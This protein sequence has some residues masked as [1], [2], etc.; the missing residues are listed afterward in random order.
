MT[1][2]SA[3]WIAALALMLALE[4]GDAIDAS[5]W[6]PGAAEAQDP[7]VVPFRLVNGFLVVSYGAIDDLAPASL[8]IDTGTARTVIHAGVADG[9]AGPRSRRPMRVFGNEAAAESVLLPSLRIGPVEKRNLDVLVAD[10]QPQERQ[11]GFT[12]DALVGLDVLGDRCITIDY[13]D[14][15]ITFAC[16]GDWSRT[17]P[18]DARTAY[19]L[20]GAIINGVRF[21]LMVDSG[22]E[23]IVLFEGAIPPD[24]RFD[25]DAEVDATHLTGTIRLKRFSAERFTLGAHDAGRPPVFIMSGQ[26][27]GLGYDG[28]LGTRWVPGGRVHLDFQRRLLAW[29]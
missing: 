28:V 23:A 16:G 26:G 10:L 14:E 4:C 8:I 1:T 19:P 20:V 15:R 22:S 3:R 12:P 9:L 17:V 6:A 7:D 13:R 18:L 25:V 27:Q 11:F 21:S 24:M 2:H 5:G 29:R